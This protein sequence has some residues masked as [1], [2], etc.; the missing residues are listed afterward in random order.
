METPLPSIHV[1]P[2]GKCSEISKLKSVNLEV[3]LLSKSGILVVGGVCCNIHPHD[4][5]D[6]YPLG[7]EDVG[8]VTLELLVHSEVHPT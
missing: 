5:I 4:C 6:Q 7:D 1:E 3:V 8:V 2:I